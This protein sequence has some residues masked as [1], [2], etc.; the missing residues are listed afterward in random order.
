M[1]L[2]IIRVEPSFLKFNPQ[3][4][5]SAS[6]HFWLVKTAQNRKKQRRAEGSGQGKV[7]IIYVFKIN[8]FSSFVRKTPKIKMR[9]LFPGFS[10]VPDMKSTN[11]DTWGVD[12]Q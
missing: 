12:F 1:L 5:R 8:H 7:L 3:G 10:A 9:L 6:Y 2:P 4:W 11:T